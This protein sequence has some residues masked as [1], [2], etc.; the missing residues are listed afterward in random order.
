MKI[1][2]GKYYRTRDGR[3]ACVICTD[4][5]ENE[6]YPVI[7]SIE[8]YV[9]TAT[10]DGRYTGSGPH[11][12]DIVAEWIDKPELPPGVVL[13]SWANKAMAMDADGSWHCYASI[14]EIGKPDQWMLSVLG[15]TQ[16]YVIPRNCTP[17]WKGDWKD[18]LVVFDKEGE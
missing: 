5:Y 17:K 9:I 3:K 1:E 16:F 10:C 15:S 18:S 13:P 12:N 8:G 4:N 7:L 14:P 11:L 2:A 6:T